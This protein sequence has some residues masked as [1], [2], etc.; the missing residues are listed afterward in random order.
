MSR[1]RPHPIGP[2]GGWQGCTFGW[3]GVN[4]L[5]RPS[6][7]SD[8]LVAVPQLHTAP[9]RA[10]RYVMSTINFGRMNFGRMR[11]LNFGFSITLPP[12]KVYKKQ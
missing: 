2:R 10:T 4:L 1:T 12:D 11:I 9:R 3:E 8:E 6:P 7:P 5:E